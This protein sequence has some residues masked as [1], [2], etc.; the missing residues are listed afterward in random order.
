MCVWKGSQRHLLE[1]ADAGVDVLVHDL[2][3]VDEVT[4]KKMNNRRTRK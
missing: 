2:I 1:E 3:D 4:K